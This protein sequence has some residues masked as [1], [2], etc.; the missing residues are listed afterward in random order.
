MCHIYI[1]FIALCLTEHLHLALRALRNRNILNGEESQRNVLN[2][3]NQNDFLGKSRLI[4][5]KSRANTK[6]PYCIYDRSPQCMNKLWFDFA[7]VNSDENT[8]TK[9]YF[10]KTFCKTAL[11]VLFVVV[12]FCFDS[13]SLHI[14]SYP[15]LS[16]KC[17]VCNLVV[18]YLLKNN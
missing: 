18:T 10:L 4:G 7:A 3:T 12:F 8:T 13:F 15:H 16:Q 14:H 2:E 1:E 11:F 5:W 17:I 9:I 6:A